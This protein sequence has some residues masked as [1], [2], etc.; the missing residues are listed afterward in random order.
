MRPIIPLFFTSLLFSG[1]LLAAENPAPTAA[2]TRLRREPEFPNRLPTFGEPDLSS[3]TRVNEKTRH[4]MSPQTSSKCAVTPTTCIYVLH[5]ESVISRGHAG[6]FTETFVNEIARPAMFSVPMANPTRPGEPAAIL[7]PVGSIIIKVKY[8]SEK[9]GDALLRTVM[10][11]RE[12][13]YNP[14][15]GDWEFVVTDGTGTPTGE[16]G[17]LQRCMEC[18]R[19]ERLKADDHTFRRDYLPASLLETIRRI[20]PQKEPARGKRNS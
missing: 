9:G 15:C 17:Q 1:F 13:G 19:S 2:T 6:A 12:K 10:I 14:D 18:H 3:W 20:E 8:A 4:R 11:K 5:A 16:R 7:F